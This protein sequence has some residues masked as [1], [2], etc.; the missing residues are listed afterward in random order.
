MPPSSCERM[1]LLCTGELVRESKL[2]QF[3]N[4]HVIGETHVYFD[5]DIGRDVTEFAIYRQSVPTVQEPTPLDRKAVA[6]YVP[7]VRRAPCSLCERSAR[8]EINQSAYDALM[9]H[10]GTGGER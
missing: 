1:F 5:R 2:S 10:Y 9:A 8:R 3:P 6:A 7:I 4:F